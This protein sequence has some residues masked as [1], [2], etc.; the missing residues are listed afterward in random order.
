MPGPP[1]DPAGMA[2]YNAQ[3]EK[4]RQDAIKKAAA[5]KKAREEAQNQEIIS[6]KSHITDSNLELLL[7]NISWA[8]NVFQPDDKN[9]IQR[10]VKITSEDAQALATSG[11]TKNSPSGSDLGIWR[12][13]GPSIT[14]LNKTIT[15]HY[16]ENI[17]KKL[18]CCTNQSTLTIPILKRNSVTG[19]IERKEKTIAFDLAN[20]C[21]INGLDWKDDNASE[22][23]HNKNCEKLMQR[24]IAFL[25]KYDDTHPHIKTYGGC[26][27]NKNIKDMDERILENPN[28]MNMVDQNRSC[29]VETCNHPLAYKRKQ[30]RKSCETTLCLADFNVSDNQ[31]G[32]AINVFGNKIEQNCGGSSAMEKELEKGTEEAEEL[33]E[34]Q[35]KEIEKAEE[36]IEKRTQELEE[37]KELKQSEEEV[38]N[39][40]QSI[41]NFF[42]SILDTFMG[43]FQSK[44][45]FKN[46]F[47]NNKI[48]KE[49]LF[50]LFI[51]F[52][53]PVF[54]IYKY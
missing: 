17:Y 13:L 42:S 40:F 54:F 26:I 34:E 12:E 35:E 10:N 21:K 31:A 38:G 4:E 19:K 3:Q 7:K 15:E 18:A 45:T 33:L 53:I 39:F 20:E 23:A 49:K 37:I 32:E 47:K 44:E 30:D 27:S 14:G 5:D 52:I 29:L 50:C 9:D 11:L 43:L 28:L 48:S 1:V 2:A 8:I 41:S 46:I 22:G 6:K 16:F 36:Q 24:Y 51:F 25:S